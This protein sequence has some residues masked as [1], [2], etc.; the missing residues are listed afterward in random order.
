LRS[1]ASDGQAGEEALVSR[2]FESLAI[3]AATICSQNTALAL[4]TPSTPVPFHRPS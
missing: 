3:A 2:W 4:A 1:F